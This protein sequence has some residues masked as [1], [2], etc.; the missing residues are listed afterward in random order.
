MRSAVLLK[1]NGGGRM[2]SLTV[3]NQRG[4][5]GKTTTV[6]TLARCFADRGMRVL[7]VDTDSQGSVWI[8]SGKEPVG[9][10]HQFMNDGISLSQVVTKIHDGID[11]IAS[12]RRTMRI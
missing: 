11:I 9:W 8:I 12:D 2:I 6:M 1:S 3:S 10:L 4:G 7:V 5:V